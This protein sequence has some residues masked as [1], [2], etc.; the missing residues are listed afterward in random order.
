MIS[1][2]P[3]VRN[4][5][6]VDRVEA[7]MMDNAS[8][9]RRLNGVSDDL[10]RIKIEKEDLIT[11]LRLVETDNDRLQRT[12]NQKDEV[13]MSNQ[14]MQEILER[15]RIDNKDM[16]SK[17]RMQQSEATQV[18]GQLNVTSADKQSLVFESHNIE[19]DLMKTLNR[20]DEC[21]KA[22]EDCIR[23]ID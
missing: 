3:E 9:Q 22:F 19:A 5:L 7:M 8:L 2:G 20:L 12:T 11:K 4:K 6:Y 14:E 18:G 23:H 21:R 10:N 17:V 13:D 16:E 15:Q 1:A